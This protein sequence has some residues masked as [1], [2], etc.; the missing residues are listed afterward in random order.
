MAS[1]QDE[2]LERLTS[3]ILRIGVIVAALITLI[4]AVIFLQ[5]K[6]QELVDFHSFREDGWQSGDYFLE[7]GIIILIIV[8]IF[9][10]FITIFYFL[11]KKDWL[12]TGIST[13]VF[14]T[15]IYTWLF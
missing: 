8:P 11:K 5:E 2:S 6:G 15:L 12:Y 10:V 9:R 1:Y 7:K 3:H 14:L 13:L 4:G